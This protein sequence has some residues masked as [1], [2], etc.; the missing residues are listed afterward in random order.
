M[1]ICILNKLFALPTQSTL[2]MLQTVFSG[3][4]FSVDW[5]R[6]SVEIGSSKDLIVPKEDIEYRAVTG[7]MGVWYDS[8]KGTSFLILPIYPSP[9]MVERA[10]E[11]GDAW[12]R[13]FVPFINLLEDP[14]LRRERRAFINS[15][16]TRLVDYP[17]MLVFHNEVVVSDSAI[18]PDN[19]DFYLS[20]MATGQV[21]VQLF[22]QATSSE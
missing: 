1:G 21:P 6:L 8:A 14:V 16:S 7:S 11:V 17:L 19:N 10:E 15:V 22:L 5:D 9:E 3:S 18:A 20:Y 2:D 4:S 13:A 12:G